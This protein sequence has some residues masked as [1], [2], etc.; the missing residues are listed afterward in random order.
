MYTKEFRDYLSVLALVCQKLTFTHLYGIDITFEKGDNPHE[1]EGYKI[2]LCIDTD[3]VYENVMIYIYPEFFEQYK[4]KQ[5]AKMGQE[6]LHEFC[7]VLHQPMK[8]IAWEHA[9]PA[10]LKQVKDTNETAVQRTSRMIDTLLPVNWAH[11]NK[12]KKLL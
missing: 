8:D 6:M 1:P 9:P 11:P 5:Y 7:H 3:T 12:I 2:P 4:N 10:I